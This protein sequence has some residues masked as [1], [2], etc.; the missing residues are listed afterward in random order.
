VR[1][2]PAT[3]P[4]T[5]SIPRKPSLRNRL[6]KRKILLRLSRHRPTSRFF[7]YLSLKRDHDK[8]SPAAFSVRQFCGAAFAG[9]PNRWNGI[10]RA[11]DLPIS[12][13]ADSG[14]ASRAD[15]VDGNAARAEGNIGSDGSRSGGVRRRQIVTP[16]RQHCHPVP[17]IS[18]GSLIRT[19]GLRRALRN[20]H[21]TADI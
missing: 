18:W 5:G 8:R 14:A 3:P 10:F 20:L 11:R 17:R 19:I 21:S 15:C 13:T 7:L 16:F 9:V 12:P 2:A 4:C 6:L 1:G